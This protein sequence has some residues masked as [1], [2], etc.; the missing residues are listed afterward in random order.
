MQ[1]KGDGRCRKAEINIKA[2]LARPSWSRKGR[3]PASLSQIYFL[4]SISIFC[5]DDLDDNLICLICHTASLHGKNVLLRL[6][7]RLSLLLFL[8]VLVFCLYFYV[9]SDTVCQLREDIQILL[10]KSVLTSVWQYT[11]HYN[12]ILAC[13]VN[14]SPL[15]RDGAN[16]TRLLIVFLIPV[17]GDR[18]LDC[19]DITRALC[20]NMSMCPI[21]LMRSYPSES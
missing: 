7:W 14:M 5:I 2:T 1:P 13:L 8:S 10:W 15:L 19:D 18:V 9:P 21:G 16:V 11:A 17:A 4:G 20:G 12:W 3:L 6:P